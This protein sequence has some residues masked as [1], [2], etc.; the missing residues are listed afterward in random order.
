M[1]FFFSIGRYLLLPQTNTHRSYL[2]HS[3]FFKI[4]STFPL[5]RNQSSVLTFFKIQ[6]FSCQ[7]SANLVLEVMCS[8][9]KF[10]LIFIT[11][12]QWPFQAFMSRV[13]GYTVW[14]LGHFLLTAIFISYTS[15][16][17]FFLIFFHAHRLWGFQNLGGTCLFGTLRY[18]H[19]KSH[20]VYYIF[21]WIS[22]YIISSI[23]HCAIVFF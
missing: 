13:Y 7:A 22:L 11:S 9:A 2:F 15:K 12:M 14:H 4:Y 5:I 10:S 3:I 16:F 1:Q 6:F 8:L 23:T 20:Y 21:Y 17:G 19:W 18:K